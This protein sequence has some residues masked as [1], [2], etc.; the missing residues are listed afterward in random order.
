MVCFDDLLK[1]KPIKEY[2]TNT[3][4]KEG[5]E[6]LRILF[7]AK[8][9]VSEFTLAELSTIYV[10]RLRSLMYKLYENRIVSYSRQKEKSRGWYIYSWRFNPSKLVEY[11]IRVL[12]EK[13]RQLKK[14]FNEFKESYFTCKNCKLKIS[15]SEAMDYDFE[16]PQC[17]SDMEMSDP[18]KEK[19]KIKKEI[20][21]IE[22]EIKK[23]EELKKETDKIVLE[24]KKPEEEPEEVVF[25]KQTYFCTKCDKPHKIDS[26][27][28]KEHR[29]YEKK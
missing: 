20:L 7:K 14:R 28:G 12:K 15:F 9:Y 2:L 26:K 27:I 4:G 19:K 11:I 18:E 23:L 22:E 5:I 17:G 16:C 10:N 25:E 1:H 6:I 8:K 29:I 24:D 21:K 3:V 13:V